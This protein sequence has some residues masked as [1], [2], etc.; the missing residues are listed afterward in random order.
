MTKS[1]RELLR[2]WQSSELGVDTLEIPSD[3]I[4][5]FGGKRWMDWKNLGELDSLKSLSLVCT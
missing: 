1:I 4:R 3:Y 2:A 5:L